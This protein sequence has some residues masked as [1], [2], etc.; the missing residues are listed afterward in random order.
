MQVFAPKQA[1]NATPAVS[2]DVSTVDILVARVA[3]PAGTIITNSMFDKQPWPQP[4]VLDSF[5][6]SNG[7][8][9]N[10]IGRVARAS[11]QAREPLISSKLS[12]ETNTGFLAASL[13]AG[14]RAITVATDTVSGVAGFV[15]PGD[16]V[17]ILF[18]H[19]IPHEL[20]SNATNRPSY[21][22]VLAA[23][24]PVLAINLRE[25]MKDENGRPNMGASTTP[26]SMTLEVSDLQAEKIRLAEKV[27]ILSISLR[28]VNDRD[29]AAVTPPADLLSL[30]NV[31]KKDSPIEDDSITI[32]RGGDYSTKPQF[33]QGSEK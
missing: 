23:D 16:R 24:I 6:V 3:I 1:P 21:A 30:T 8:N 25:T 12:D 10:I 5:I 7:N 19:N 22:E 27:G 14:M 20:K 18:L 33:F 11:F 13:P 4:L 32:V 28:S 15:F 2:Q 17:D 31:S 29:N 26:T 9:A